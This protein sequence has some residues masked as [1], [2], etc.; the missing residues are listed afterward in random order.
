MLFRE[1]IGVYFK[2]NTEPIHKICG[3]N[4]KLL[5]VKADGTYAYHKI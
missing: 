1:L 5:D 2:N 4:M 3:Q